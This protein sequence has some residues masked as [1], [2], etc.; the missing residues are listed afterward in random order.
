M[1]TR[2]RVDG[3][4]FLPFISSKIYIAPLQDPYSEALF[5]QAML[6]KQCSTLLEIENRH[7][8]GGAF[9]LREAHSR[10]LDHPHKWNDCALS[11][12]GLIGPSSCCGQRT[13]V[14]SGLH[15]A[16]EE[17][18]WQSLHRYDWSSQIRILWST[19][20]TY[21]QVLYVSIFY[22]CVVIIYLCL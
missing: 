12:N 9:D 15:I 7:C 1:C 2:I 3:T 4:A 13:A 5:T 20:K 16:Q 21:L 14:F 10:L 19:V 6:K 18:R 11:Q 8:L 22:L 17:R